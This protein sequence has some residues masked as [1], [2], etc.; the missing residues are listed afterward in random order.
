MITILSYGCDWDVR[1]IACRRCKSVLAYENGVR[2]GDL[3]ARVKDLEAEVSLL[4]SQTGKAVPVG[5][6]N[7]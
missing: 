7:P 1:E 4:R 6:V 5:G 2:R 3:E